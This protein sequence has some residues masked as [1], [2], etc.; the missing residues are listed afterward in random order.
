MEFRYIAEEITEKEIKKVL[1]M[2]FDS[3]AKL[4]RYKRR[5]EHNYIEVYYILP[6]DDTVHRIDLLPDNLYDMDEGDGKE[7]V[8]G[9][10]NWRYMQ[11]T[12]AKGYSELWVNNPYM[13]KY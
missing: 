4:V 6:S 8:N 2:V 9:E 7:F 12:T 3:S 1:E 13:E 5:T 10:I 11:F